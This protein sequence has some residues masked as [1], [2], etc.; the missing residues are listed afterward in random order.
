M[1]DT[2]S[3]APTRRRRPRLAIAQGDAVPTSDSDVPKRRSRRRKKR[4]PKDLDP[5]FIQI[6]AQVALT[7]GTLCL[8]TYYLWHSLFPSGLFFEET[9]EEVVEDVY[10]D[11]VT[12]NAQL[13]EEAMEATNNVS[14]TAAPTI[15]TAPP[16]PVWDLGDASKYDAFRIAEMHGYSTPASD[17]T[18]EFWSTAE[19]LRNQFAELY[20][21]ENAVR[22]M[23]ERGLTMFPRKSEALN[24]KPPSD[25]V[26]TACRIR[27]AK[28]EQRPFKFTFGG[29]SV[30]VGRGNYFGQSFPFVMGKILKNPFQDLGVELSVMN[31]AIGGCPS[32]PYGFCKNEHWGEDSDVV[33]WD[34]SMNEAGGVAEGLEAYLRH[35]MTLSHRPKLIVKDTQM[36]D[37]RRELLGTYVEMG[38]IDDPVVL[39]S[40]PAVRPFLDRRD[41]WRPIGFQSWR[42]FGSP[43]GAPGQALHHPA[44]KEHEMLGWMLAMHF[45]SALELVAA[46]Q[47]GSTEETLQ[48]TCPTD[49]EETQNRLT[50]NLLPPPVTVN[51]ATMESWS[52]LFYGVPNS[53]DV[54]DAESAKDQIWKMNPVHCRTSYDPIVDKAGSLTSIVV[55]GSAGENLDPML[56]KGHFFYNQ[57]WVLDLS[58]GEKEAKRKLDRFGGLGYLDSKKAYRG[59][60]TSG[61][62][63]L[64]L[65]FYYDDNSHGNDKPRPNVG[66]SARDWYQTIVLCEVNEKRGSGACDVAKDITFKTGGINATKVAKLNTPGTLYLGKKICTYIDVPEDAKISSREAM[67]LEDPLLPDD[68][69]LELTEAVKSGLVEVGLSLELH[70]HNHFLVAR[71][72]ACSISQVV[73]EQRT[74]DGPRLPLPTKNRA[75]ANT[76]KSSNT[77]TEELDEDEVANAAAQPERKPLA[78]YLDPGDEEEDAL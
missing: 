10:D 78:E 30:T 2:S 39:H 77:K 45:L 65:P 74:P 38:S 7:L 18:R 22:A 75:E 17:S 48:F 20:G 26:S 68:R 44:V 59:L 58:E 15:P 32:F 14:P 37:K 47:D 53:P 60:F 35:T 70:V 16:L 55:S 31:A 3:D 54:A 27:R 40:D 52:S 62:F 43:P 51:A 6:F 69:K 13:N 71:E 28:K 76:D 34:F 41:S 25:L 33:S 73:W 64:L 5:P 63:R 72:T 23:M 36:A 4:R 1:E 61:T 12:V 29:Y 46:A 56:P 57:A 11:D 42:K 66:D 50:T 67:L 21:G 9:Y 24:G 8:A 49:D 19:S